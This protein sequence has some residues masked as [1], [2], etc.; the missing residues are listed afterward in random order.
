LCSM[1]NGFVLAA[2]LDASNASAM[3]PETRN[4]RVHTFRMDA[5]LLSGLPYAVV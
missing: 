3:V 4:V 1:L 5:L 2:A